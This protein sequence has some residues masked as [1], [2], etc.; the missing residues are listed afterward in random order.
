MNNVEIEK[1]K[2]HILVEF[3]E[4]VPNATVSKTILRKLTGNISVSSLD[5]GEGFGERI[6]PFDTFIQIIDG[7][8]EI[9]IEGKSNILETGNG[10]I[11]PAHKSSSI[12]ANNRFKMITTTIKSGYEEIIV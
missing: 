6:S 7:T 10:I 3:I 2:V 4:Y 9:V 11:I 8:A 1:S 5:A 12:K